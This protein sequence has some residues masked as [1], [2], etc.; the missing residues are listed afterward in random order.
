[1]SSLHDLIDSKF[2]E[3]LVIS[4]IRL[5]I[6]NKKIDYNKCDIYGISPF[7][8]ACSYGNLKIIEY[9]AGLPNINIFKSD[10]KNISPLYIACSNGYFEVVKY[11]CESLGNNNKVYLDQK[12]MEE[13]TAFYCCIQCDYIDIAKYLLSLGANIDA[14][15]ED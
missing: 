15:D 1:M 7:Y 14:A 3:L 13:C 8:L 5:E 10:R 11:L 12:C 4:D 2:S 9:F 6:E